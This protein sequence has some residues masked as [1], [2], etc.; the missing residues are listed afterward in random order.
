MEGESSVVADGARDHKPVEFEEFRA[1]A[2]FAAIE[3]FKHF[4]RDRSDG[5]N[6]TERKAVATAFGLTKHENGRVVP[7][8]EEVSDD[9]HVRCFVTSSPGM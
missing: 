7:A 3:L 4:D 5:L 9:I 1:F 6:E 2:I 8:D